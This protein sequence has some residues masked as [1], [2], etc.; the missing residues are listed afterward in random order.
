MQ[1]A[2]QTIPWLLA[3]TACGQER[4]QIVLPPADLAVCSAEPETPI[5]PP[6]GVERDRVV[7]EYVLDLREAWADCAAKVAGLKAWRDTAS[8]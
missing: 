4:P 6:P 2:I 3:L 7:L 1:R 8:R 5:L